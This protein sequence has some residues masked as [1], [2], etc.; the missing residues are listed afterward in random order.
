MTAMAETLDC[1]LRVPLVCVQI[2]PVCYSRAELPNANDT[3]TAALRDF[4]L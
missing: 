3:T 1:N 2:I 4:L